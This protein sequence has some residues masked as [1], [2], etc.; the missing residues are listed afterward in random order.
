MD[1]ESAL[2]FILL[3]KEAMENKQKFNRLVIVR[4]NY[5]SVCPFWPG[6]PNRTKLETIV[7]II[8]Y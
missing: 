2:E 1:L 5:M 3:S 6:V 4:R 7:A 8:T